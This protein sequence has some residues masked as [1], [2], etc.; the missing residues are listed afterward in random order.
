MNDR[1][2]RSVCVFCGSQPGIRAEYL[3]AARRFGALLASRDIELVYGGAA[4]GLMGAV[5]DAALE[6]GGRVYGVIPTFLAGNEVAHTR[7]TELRLVDSMHERKAAMA[8]RAEAFV[9]LPGGYG[10]LDEMFEMLTFGQIG[11]MDK[12]SG[13]LNIGGF[14]DGLLGYLD[15]AAAEGFIRP[16]HRALLHADGAPEALLD[17]LSHARGTRPVIVPGGTA[18]A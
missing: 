5:A 2:L 14:F 6:G 7:L 8:D 12:P 1:T 11:M 15:F 3:A 13:L 4:V 9:S 10:T 18:R 17:K 16:A